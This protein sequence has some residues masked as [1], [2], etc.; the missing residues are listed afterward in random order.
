VIFGGWVKGD[1]GKQA[2]DFL[3]FFTGGSGT[4]LLDNGMASSGYASGGGVPVSNTDGAW[5]FISRA[6]KVTALG[7]GNVMYVN[8]TLLS[9]PAAS[10][11]YPFVVYVPASAGVAD[12]EVIRWQRHLLKGIIPANASA[13]SLA[14]VITATSV[15][16]LTNK[17]FDTAGAGNVLKINGTQ[18]NS[19]TG[20]G[21]VVLAGAPTFTG[22]PVTPSGNATTPGIQIGAA[23]NGLSTYAGN[24]VDVLVGGATVVQILPGQENLQNGSYASSR[25]TN[26]L[27]ANR[28]FATPDG[29]SYSVMPGSLTTT[30]A[31]SDAV[32]M[33]GMTSGGHCSL[34]ATNLSAATNLA[35]T[36]VSAKTTNQI[37]VTHAAT[38]GM[39][40]DVLCTSN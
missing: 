9:L 40:Y 23:G 7:T 16:T 36:Y 22:A 19:S 10:F 29:A 33:Q 1:A 32:T 13:G 34:T 38:A 26:T 11:A 20:S 3:L 25:Q 12:A 8:P 28:T 21:A 39:T 18:V 15:A 14:G 24:Q 35:T 37:T 5:H 4:P 2:G 17:T 27:T 6:V 31:T 30:S